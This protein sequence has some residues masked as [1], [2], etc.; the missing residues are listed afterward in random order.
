MVGVFNIFFIVILTIGCLVS[1]FGIPL[2]VIYWFAVFFGATKRIAKAEKKLEDTLMQG[3]SLVTQGIQ[4]RP[5]AFFSRRKLVGITNSRIIIISRGLLGGFTMQDLQWKDLHDAQI[6]EN[7]LSNLCGSNLSF[8][9]INQ[10]I[11][12]PGIE[13]SAATSI[14]QKAQAEEQAWE[15]KR[16]IR[17]LEEMRAAAGGV[18]VNPGSAQSGYGSS[19]NVSSSVTEEIEKAKKLLDSGA[20]NDAEFQEIKS[21]ILSKN[22]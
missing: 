16:R 4:Q 14:Y 20:I 11:S 8:N 9:T 18:I 15:E 3:E 10:V 7:V 6:S 13:N 5:F 22:F 19:G 12:V 2:I 17:S 1:F 21:K